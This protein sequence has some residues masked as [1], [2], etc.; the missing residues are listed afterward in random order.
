[1]KRKHDDGSV[2]TVVKDN[3]LNKT[4]ISLASSKPE[5]FV[6]RSSKQQVEELATDNGMEME[7]VFLK[8]AGCVYRIGQRAVI[9]DYEVC[10]TLTRGDDD[11]VVEQF[12]GSGSYPYDAIRNACKKAKKYLF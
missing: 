3:S 7:Y 8:P 4:N 9:G 11:D 1:M 2:T 12:S 5:E 10:L 6:K